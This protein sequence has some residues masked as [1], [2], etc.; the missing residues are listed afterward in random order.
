MCP[1]S[2]FSKRRL[3]FHISSDARCDVT[4]KVT[5]APTRPQSK[6]RSVIELSA[7]DDSQ[8]VVLHK[9]L[10]TLDL[11]RSRLDSVFPASRPRAAIGIPAV[12]N[13]HRTVS[14]THWS[15]RIDPSARTT[16]L[17]IGS[18]RPTST[19]SR[20]P[21]TPFVHIRGGRP[22]LD[23]RS[24]MAKCPSGLAAVAY[25]IS[26]HRSLSGAHLASEPSFDDGSR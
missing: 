8:V 5:K 16:N 1:R 22:A 10:G 9:Y 15:G 13:P 17:E 21:H 20:K 14:E 26:A 11:I 4:A 6:L 23:A 24:P 19:K 3:I 12:Q 2:H 7:V 18:N 25:S